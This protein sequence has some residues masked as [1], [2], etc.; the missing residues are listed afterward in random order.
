MPN[1]PQYAFDA[2]HALPCGCVA[3]IY[4]AQPWDVEV[5]SLEARGPHC[6]DSEHQMG[7]L[8]GVAS[9]PETNRLSR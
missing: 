3:G 6:L 8:L 1:A 2:F 5:V 7:R 4:K 9:N